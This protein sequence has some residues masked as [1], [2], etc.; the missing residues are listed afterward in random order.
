MTHAELVAPKEVR[1]STK[2][3]EGNCIEMVDEGCM[4]PEDV[5]TGM[6]VG[7]GPP[8]ALA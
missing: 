2:V 8:I 6:V 7:N 4:I 1:E 5:M 3:D